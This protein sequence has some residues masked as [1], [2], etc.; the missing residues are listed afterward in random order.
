MQKSE[1]GSGLC[2]LTFSCVD[3]SPQIFQLSVFYFFI[4]NS[5]F[6]T[7]ISDGTTAAAGLKGA[8]AFP[9]SIRQNSSCWILRS[10]SFRPFRGTTRTGWYFPV[11]RVVPVARAAAASE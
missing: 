2:I 10:W 4:L 7:L 1:P 6:R 11:V 5:H 8:V 3:D 9:D